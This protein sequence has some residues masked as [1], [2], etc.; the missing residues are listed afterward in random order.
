M[1]LDFEI[2]RIQ[3]NTPEWLAYRLS[4][5]G[6]SD[7]AAVLGL[8]PF[9]TNV[10]VWEEKVGARQA[11]DISDKPYVLYG[12]EAETPLVSLF[13]LD[14]PEY[15]ATIDKM[16][17]Y[18]RGFMFAS[19]DGELTERASGRRGVLEVKTTELYKRADLSK[20][21]G[22]IPMYYYI[23]VLHQLIVTGWDFS[24]LKAQIKLP[25]PQDGQQETITRHYAFERKDRLADMKYLYL[26]ER[27]FW[28]YVERRERPP[29]LLPALEKQ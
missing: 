2:V 5:I 22:C 8:S 29:L 13:R 28:G 19:L 20:W 4:G 11:E 12:Q 1:S 24:V 26:K 3:H 14:Y 25:T 23:Q 7:A 21:N 6:G 10:E 9:K 15:S 16:V 17:V 27:E 18:R